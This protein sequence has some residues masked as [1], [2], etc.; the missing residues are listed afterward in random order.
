[1]LLINMFNYSSESVTLRYIR[2]TISKLIFEPG[3]LT[4]G[5]PF[6]GPKA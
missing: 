2:G 1:M 4:W 3:T 6:K 5:L